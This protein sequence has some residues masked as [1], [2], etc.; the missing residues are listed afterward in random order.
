[1]G[2]YQRI[3]DWKLKLIY[4]G[5]QLPRASWFQVFFNHTAIREARSQSANM[6]A[7]ENVVVVPLEPANTCFTREDFM[8]STF[9]VDGF[10][11]DCKRNVS[12]EVLKTDLDE[13]LKALKH[14]LIELINQDY[15][16]FVNLSSNLMIRTELDNT[17]VSIEE[18][19]DQRSQLRQ[20]KVCMQHLLNITKSL[21]KIERLLKGSLADDT[22]DIN[23][24]SEDESHLI[25]RVASEFNQLQFYVTQS[26]G[27]PLV[28]NIRWRIASIT[29]TL[30]KKL[31][32]AFQEGIK[33]NQF[34]LLARVLRT[35]A[36]I[37]KIKD[38]ELLFR[39]VLVKPYM[40]EIISEQAF[41]SDPENGLREIYT[42]ILEFIPKY[43]SNMLHITSGGFSSE[44][45]GPHSEGRAAIR[46]FD[47][48]VNSIWPEAV[49]LIETRLSS[50]F[51]P[52]NPDAF[53]KKYRTSMWFVDKFELL[54]C[55]K[56]SVKRLRDHP[57]YSAFMSRWSLPVYF[58]IR[59]QEIA[60]KLEL[61]LSS[62]SDPSIAGEGPLL[63]PVGNVL[64]WALMRCWDDSVYIHALCHRFWKLTLQSIA[65]FSFWL[66]SE[67]SNEDKAGGETSDVLLAFFV[68]LLV[69]VINLSKKIPEHFNNVILPKLARIGLK[70]TTILTDA[71]EDSVKTLTALVPSLENTIIKQVSNRA[72]QGLDAVRNIPRLYRRTNREVPAN[73]SPFVSMA[74]KPVHDFQHQFRGLVPEEQRCRWTQQV[75][76][77]MFNRY[78]AMTSEVLTSIKKTEDSLLRLKRTRKQGAGSTQSSGSAQEGM[79]DDDKIRLQFALDVEEFSKLMQELEVDK[80]SCPA[81]QEVFSFVQSARAGS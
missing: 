48:M 46:G 73:A 76:Q 28:E 32:D 74:I 43:C 17:I 34:D 9:S 21:E 4:T 60:G 6:A 62:P 30:Q 20:K 47:F 31:E 24:D 8:K 44:E 37:D 78:N 65:R 66:K 12:L 11:S 51:A 77:A 41:L 3:G 70:D 25:E 67:L 2:E 42:K 53:H 50:V 64:L 16:D 10:V 35:Y 15:A 38:A 39:E 29:I 61:V 36:I 80:N 18:K 72:T 54:C 79:S 68:H 49:H 1:M 27:H 63:T 13:Y 69:D 22:A 81:F 33:S 57:S 58:Q 59:L 23:E 14:A 5:K 45:T 7:S 40:N 55:S 52:G 26:Q 71:L 19:L 56:A 75:L